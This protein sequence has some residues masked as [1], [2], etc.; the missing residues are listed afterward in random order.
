MMMQHISVE[1]GAA[2]C[3]ITFNRDAKRNAFCDAMSSEVSAAIDRALEQGSQAIVLTA[4]P[5]TAIWSSGHDLTEIREPKDLIQ[6]TMFVLLQQI[7]SCPIPV[8]CAVDG[9]V[10]AGGFLIT[11][12]ADIVLVTERSR[13]CM[14]IN[15]M[16]IPLPR[17]CYQFAMQALGVHKAKEMFLCA[18]LMTA[19]D[20]YAHGLVNHVVPDPAQLQAQLDQVLSGIAACLPEGLAYTK[21]V[22]NS[23][24]Q[25]ASLD[26]PAAQT[27]A[28]HFERLAESPAVAQRIEALVRKIGRRS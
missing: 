21:A 16:G 11:L 20:V 18:N 1:Y 2:V 17:Y 15:K 4:N 22:F 23:L 27:L 24:T 8:I 26:A 9:D 12:L 7:A 5:G 19:A 13:F 6:D 28:L 10:Y 25:D 14:P 3:T